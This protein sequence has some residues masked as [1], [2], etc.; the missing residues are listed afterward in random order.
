MAISILLVLAAQAWAGPPPATKRS[1]ASSKHRPPTGKSSKVKG[2]S[3]RAKAKKE[4]WKDRGQQNIY[5][6]RATAI[7]QALIREKYLSGEPSGKWDDETQAAMA[8]YQADNGWQSK[9]TPDSRALIKL[10]LG[11]DYSEKNMMLYLPKPASDPVTAT[12]SAG[13]ASSTKQR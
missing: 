10:G 6:E 13:T 4:T 8:R 1:S 9:V 11:P 12:T 5:P 2:R 3:R 7:Q